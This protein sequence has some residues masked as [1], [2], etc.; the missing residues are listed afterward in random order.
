MRRTIISILGVSCVVGVL[1]TGGGASAARNDL[2]NGGTI[3]RTMSAAPEPLG[4][5]GRSTDLW[6]CSVPRPNLGCWGKWPRGGWFSQ[7]PARYAVTAA[8]AHGGRWGVQLS[9]RG[10]RGVAR[11]QLNRSRDTTGRRWT[12]DV[13]RQYRIWLKIPRLVP[14]NPKWWNVFQFTSTTQVFANYVVETCC[15]GHRY[16]FLVWN[17]IAYKAVGTSRPFRAGQWVKL[18]ARW[19]PD[20][21]NGTAAFFL[22]G[23]LIGR[24]KG[25]TRSGPQND[26]MWEVASYSDNLPPG[27]WSVDFDD[28]RVGL[29]PSSALRSAGFR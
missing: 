29:A 7:G 8:A 3:A 20:R 15:S 12:D 24:V 2:S 9:I 18:M 22:N 13:N 6:D 16:R 28:A 10:A 23:R 1:S 4:S 25:Q 17:D 14:S 11:S 27:W 21:T 19:K 5:I 26:N